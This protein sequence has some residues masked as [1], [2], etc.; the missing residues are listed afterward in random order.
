MDE[1][2][3]KQDN[4]TDSARLLAEARQAEEQLRSFAWELEQRNE[5]LRK[6]EERYH[7]MIAEIEDYAIILLDTNGNIQ[8]W[9]TGAEKIKGYKAEEIIGKNFRIFYLPQ[10]RDNKLPEKLLERVIREGKSAYEG[11]RVRKDGSTFW[12]S[13]VVTA[14]HDDNGEVIG[15]SKVTRD[16]TEKKKAEDKM[17][18]YLAELENR[19]SELE[20]FAY[21]A[22]HDLQEP[23]RKIQTFTEVIERNLD[24]EVIVKRYFEKINTSARRMVELITSVL[25]YS[26]LSKERDLREDADLNEVL[27]GI[28]S[29][30][31]LPIREKNAKIVYN[32]LPVLKAHPLQMHQ[33]FSNL[34]SNALKFSSGSPVITISSQKIAKEGMK[35]SPVVLTAG[36]YLEIVVKDNGIGFEQEYENLIFSMFQRLH[37]RQEY[38][39]TGIGLAICKK[40][41]ENHKGFMRAEGEPR[42][43]S[44][45]YLY[46]PLY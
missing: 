21:I 38:A 28:E 31:E 37:P 32:G 35:S 46:F 11:W 16:L 2:R 29:D 18:E 4:T 45:F 23:M 15:L 41:M 24:D 19:N 33:L 1:L 25:N 10:D 9:N 27:A 26:R 13:I 17:R 22:S 12:G 7:K 36:Q 39:G 6:S 30:F 34:I 5:T 14:L 8:N 44:S 43:G 3:K 42:K 20:Q 40:I